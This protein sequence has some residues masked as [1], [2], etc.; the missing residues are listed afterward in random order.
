MNLKMIEFENCS[1][2]LMDN[3]LGSSYVGTCS[4]CPLKSSCVEGFWSIRVDPEGF[5]QPCLLRT[6]LRIDISELDILERVRNK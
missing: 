5:A 4:A 2:R 1:V 3:S 6:D